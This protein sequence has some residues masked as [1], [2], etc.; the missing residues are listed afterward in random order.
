MFRKTKKKSNSDEEIKPFDWDSDVVA[1]A[2]GELG[3]R[4]EEFY[5]MPWCEF[6]IKSYAYSRMQE[7]KLRHTRLIAY[8]AQIGSH[9]DPKK[10]PR[11]IDQFMPI[12]SEKSARKSNKNVISDDMK[13]LFKKRMQEYKNQITN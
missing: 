9:L 11:T 7:E 4:L 2:C 6:L 13:E 5:E 12:G 10:L 1:F 8:S 3:L